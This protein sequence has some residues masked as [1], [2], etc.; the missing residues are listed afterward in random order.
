MSKGKKMINSTNPHDIKTETF[1]NL[2]FEDYNNIQAEADELLRMAEEYRMNN[3]LINYKMAMNKHK[4]YLQTLE[5]LIGMLI[6]NPTV[7]A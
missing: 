6:K 5:T 7:E 2:Y 3:Q 4:I 1:K